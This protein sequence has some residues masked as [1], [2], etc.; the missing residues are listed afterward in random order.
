MSQ[1]KSAW[2]RIRSHFYLSL[3]LDIFVILSIF[4]AIHAWQ[5]RNLPLDEPAPETALFLLKGSGIHPAVTPGETGIVYFFATRSTAHSLANPASGTAHAGQAGDFT[6]GQH[7][8]V[9]N[10][11]N[12][13]PHGFYPVVKVG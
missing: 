1:F 6:I 5:T 13:V 10:T 3:V 11:V 8:A 2:Q 7:V 4:L 9:R 12:H